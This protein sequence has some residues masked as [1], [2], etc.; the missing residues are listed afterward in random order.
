MLHASPYVI[1]PENGAIDQGEIV[2]GCPVTSWVQSKDARLQGGDLSDD[3][4]K[5]STTTLI[6]VVV[7]TQTCDL[8][9]EK[10]PFVTLCALRTLEVAKADWLKPRRQQPANID[11]KWRDHLREVNNEK[12]SLLVYLPKGSID[13]KSIP[14]RLVSLCPALTL[15]YEFLNSLVTKRDGEQRLRLN[16]PFRERLSYRF[17]ALYARVGVEDLDRFSQSQ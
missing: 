14:A 6:D 1:I 10:A 15:P 16:S 5:I 2:L 3:L 11:Q 9:Q 13:G 7:L 8:A 17:A 4:D 12:H